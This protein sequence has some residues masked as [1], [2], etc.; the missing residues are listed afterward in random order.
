MTLARAAASSVTADASVYVTKVG[1]PT[2]VTVTVKDQFGNPIGAPAQVSI[3]R[4][5]R[6]GSTDDRPRHGRRLGQG[7]HQP[8]GRRHR[9]GTE[10]FSINLYDDQF[11]ATASTVR[12]WHDQLHRRP[13]TGADFAVAGATADPAATKIIAALR[14]SR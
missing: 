7:H 1:S 5:A 6:N 9:A 14:R 12:R 4:G 3:V 8:A 2:V 11:D 13:V 10:A